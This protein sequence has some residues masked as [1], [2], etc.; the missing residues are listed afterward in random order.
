[1]TAADIVPEAPVLERQTPLSTPLPLVALGGLEC[2]MSARSR[3]VS[4]M[5]G[6]TKVIPRSAGSVIEVNVGGP[7]RLRT[8][9][10]SVSIPEDCVLRPG[11]PEAQ[12]ASV[13]PVPRLT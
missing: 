3:S 5:I 10:V 1:M 9:R 12:R 7:G 2:I 8:L 11:S 13:H 6:T 4:R